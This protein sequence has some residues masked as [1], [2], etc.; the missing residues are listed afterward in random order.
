MPFLLQERNDN[1]GDE[2]VLLLVLHEKSIK[3]IVICSHKEPS[4][5]GHKLQCLLGRPAMSARS[6]YAMFQRLS[7]HSLSGIDVMSRLHT[8][9]VPQSMLPADPEHTTEGTLDSQRV[10][11]VFPWHGLLGT[12][13]RRLSVLPHDDLALS[14]F[15]MLCGIN[16]IC[17]SK[18]HNINT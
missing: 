12:M 14:C 2:G 15:M 13:G 4:E 17:R 9:Y 18:T 11:D 16:T 5:I 6:Q 1:L 8:A 10:R 7:P 3:L